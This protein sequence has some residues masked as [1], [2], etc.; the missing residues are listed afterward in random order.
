MLIYEKQ[1]EWHP[2]DD[3]CKGRVMSYKHT[4]WGQKMFSEVR[5][6]GSISIIL[7]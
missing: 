4:P 6:Y 1:L 7:A 2:E 5:I 3:T